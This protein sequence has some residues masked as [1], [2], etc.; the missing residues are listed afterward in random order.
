ML[1]VGSTGLQASGHVCMAHGMHTWC[2]HGTRAHMHITYA[3][4][5]RSSLSTPVRR[6]IQLRRRLEPKKFAAIH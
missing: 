4:I 2:R 6:H 3:H 5:G 1:V